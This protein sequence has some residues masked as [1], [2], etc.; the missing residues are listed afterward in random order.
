MQG[1]SIGAVS[2]FHVG[3]QRLFVVEN[4]SDTEFVGQHLDQLHVESTDPES[5]GIEECLCGAVETVDVVVA[6]VEEVAHFFEGH[7]TRWVFG[8]VDADPGAQRVDLCGGV[9][10]PPV[11]A[12]DRLSDFGHPGGQ[13]LEL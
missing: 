13:L 1:P 2:P 3:A 9:D 6:V 8:D 12:D 11:Q 10:H 4:G 7:R 5:V